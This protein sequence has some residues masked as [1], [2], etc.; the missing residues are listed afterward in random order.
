MKRVLFVDDDANVLAGLRRTLRVMRDEW[1]MDFVESPVEALES[2]ADKGFDVIVSDMRMPDMDG[3]EL[4][5]QVQQ[6]YPESVRIILS[7]DSN[8]EMIMRSIG[9]AHQYLAKPCEPDKLKS[10][11]QRAYVLKDL[12]TNE[13]I[14]RIVSGI[15]ELPTGSSNYREIAACLEDPRASLSDIRSI[16]AKDVGMT[17]KVLQLVNSAFFGIS[18]PVTSVENAV[19]LLGRDTIRT[20]VL[21]HGMFSRY[22]DLGTSGLSSEVLWHYSAKCAA[23]AKVVSEA[24]G[25]SPATVDEAFVSGMLHD[26]G[27]LVLASEKPEQYAEV[28]RR[29]GGQESPSDEVELEI[30]GATHGEVGAYLIGLWGLPDSIVEAVAFHEKP[31]Q[32]N[33][34]FGLFGVVHVA[35]KLAMDSAVTDPADPALGLDVDYLRAAG[36]FDRWPE[37]RAACGSSL[38]G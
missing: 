9:S 11:I 32:C 26:V 24:E 10:T 35:S 16:V 28:L 29:V 34:H 20:L 13:S 21:S 23:I 30:F 31:A 8:A 22:G 2:F 18:E 36:V 25:M 1:E 3:A 27:K 17:A 7:G 37:W 33:S 19:N 4:L 15:G 38:N 5:R 6:R 12:V 14:G